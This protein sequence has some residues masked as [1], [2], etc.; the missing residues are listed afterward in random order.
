MR[1]RRRRTARSSCTRRTAASCRSSRRAITC[2]TCARDSRGARS[3]R[4]S[5]SSDV[6]GIAVTA[7]PGLA[8]ALLVGVQAAKALALA[9]EHAARRRRSPGRPPAAR[10]S[11][12]SR[13]RPRAAAEYPFVALLVSGGHTALYRVDGPE[14]DAVTRARRH[15][16]RRRRRSLRQG[17]QAARA[18]AIRAARSSIKL[19]HDGDRDALR[20]AAADAP[21]RLAR[22]QL[23]GPEEQRRALRRAA[24]RARASGSAAR[25]VRGV[26][27]ARRR[28]RWSTRRVARC[29]A[30]GPAAPGCSAAASPPTA[31]CA[32]RP[33]AAARR[34][35]LALVVP[36][37]ARC[38]DNA[39]MIAFAGASPARR[40]RIR[41]LLEVSPYTELPT[42]TRK[43]RGARPPP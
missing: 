42:T 22:V 19:A 31:G 24:R 30:R 39:A 32:P 1:Q 9:R 16:R 4:A 41:P 33:R 26:P 11:C 17:R 12:R 35:R 25:P 14:L 37:S 27:S 10:C 2:A 15:A 7:R 40:R 23:L 43:G 3:A 34:A 28:A 8:G 38:T 5:S 18:S 29:D 21:Q 36:P 6:D 13:A 20:A